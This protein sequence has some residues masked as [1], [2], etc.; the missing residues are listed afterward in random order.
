MSFLRTVVL[1]TLAVGLA[2]VAHAQSVYKVVVNPANP[3][4]SLSRAELARLFLKKSATWPD[5]ATV[6]VVDQERGSPVRQSFSLGI[7]QK[8]ADAIAAYWQ[9]AVFSGRD[10]PPAIA[11]SDAEVLAFVRANPGAVGYVSAEADIA[12]VKALAVK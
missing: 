2:T 8:S 10:V 1:L 3:T 5:G 9:T 4:A 6:A 7:H 11:K 12:G